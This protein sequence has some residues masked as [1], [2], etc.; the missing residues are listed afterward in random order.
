MA[1]EWSHD[2]A[3]DWIWRIGTQTRSVMQEIL[4]SEPI[5]ITYLWVFL[6][7]FAFY[8]VQVDGQSL[9]NTASFG[10]IFLN[11]IWLAPLL[12]GIYWILT[13]SL[14]WFFG[15]VWG[16][17]ATW[18]EM[19]TTVAWSYIPYLLKL[20]LIWLQFLF[21]GEEMFA[22]A[23]LITVLD[24]QLLLIFFSLLKIVVTVWFYIVQIRGVAEVHGIAT[25]KAATIVISC[26]LLL[27]I[28]LLWLF[29]LLIFPI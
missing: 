6:Y 19:T 21:F 13:S 14:F 12:G 17:L 23:S 15:R 28:L 5:G 16:G 1:L 27:S 26:V 7:G 2:K 4:A 8:Y 22:S 25:W 24:L 10:S 20:V 18:Q 9:G 3:K 29:Q 11:G